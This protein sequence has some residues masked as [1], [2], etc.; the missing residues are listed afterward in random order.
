MMLPYSFAHLPMTDT[1]YV[2]DTKLDT[3][4]QETKSPAFTKLTVLRGEKQ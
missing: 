4:K 1:Y 3:C 2:P